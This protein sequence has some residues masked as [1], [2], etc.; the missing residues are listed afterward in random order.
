VQRRLVVAAAKDYQMALLPAVVIVVE[1]RQ[2]KTK[3]QVL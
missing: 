3:L 2:A 1:P